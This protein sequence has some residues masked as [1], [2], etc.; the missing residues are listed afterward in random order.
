M[1]LTETSEAS[2]T[3]VV[4]MT[5]GGERR[6]CADDI[7]IDDGVLAVTRGN[8]VAAV[9]APG[10]WVSA[11]EDGAL[12]PEAKG[13]PKGHALYIA[14][15]ALTDIADDTA[16]DAEA[17]RAAARHALDRAAEAHPGLPS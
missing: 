6:Y 9:Y 3:I 5:A 4:T 7:E 8:N 11:H 10:Q 12:A 2:A 14:V 1:I 15:N 16:R 17:L 13:D